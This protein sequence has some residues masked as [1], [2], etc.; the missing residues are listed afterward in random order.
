MCECKVKNIEFQYGIYKW[1][2]VK[3]I[4]FSS[5]ELLYI[6]NRLDRKSETNENLIRFLEILRTALIEE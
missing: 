1:D 4:S 3:R 5:E 2:G 6:L